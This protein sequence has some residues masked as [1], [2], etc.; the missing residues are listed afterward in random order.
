MKVW[1][2]KYLFS[3]G[4]LERE[5]EEENGNFTGMITVHG[6]RP[7]YYHCE[8]RDWHRTKGS[9]VRRANE[10]VRIKIATL[11]KQLEILENLKFEA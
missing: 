2:T 1:I 7:E 11:K 5:A 10:M 4:I 9:A 8:G 6:P 3:Q